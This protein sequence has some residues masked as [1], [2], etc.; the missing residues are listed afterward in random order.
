MRRPAPD[1]VSGRDA[2]TVV[3]GK[4]DIPEVSRG[5][6]ARDRNTEEPRNGRSD[7]DD[8]GYYFSVNRKRGI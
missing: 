7:S 1:S 4:T 2:A 5:T 3:R 6:P 8:I